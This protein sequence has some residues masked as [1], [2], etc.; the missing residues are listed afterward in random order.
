MSYSWALYDAATS[1]TRYPQ[2]M[3][4]LMAYMLSRF[5][6][7]RSMGICHCRN[8]GGGTARSHHSECRAGDLGFP[9]GAGGSYR[10]ELGDPI[11]ELL[12][13]HG[14]ELG[15]DHLIM[16]RRI[17]SARTPDGRYYSGASPHY[18]HAH[19][20]CT[21]YAAKNLTM[22][23]IVD[24]LGPVG[25]GIPLPPGDNMENYIEAQQV[26]LNAAG[27]KGANGKTLTVDN[28]YGKNT[29]YAEAA[30]DKDAASAGQEFDT[31]NVLR[32]VKR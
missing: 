8:I 23:K 24:I 19:I 12:G 6:Y 1:C 7:T 10:A 26:N 4:N 21:R 3:T 17:W 11:I 30:R 16:N 28:I 18:D 29:Q 14:K 22:A 15:L 9:T 25:P 2:G 13:P 20:G 31:I 32:R 5:A 27:Y